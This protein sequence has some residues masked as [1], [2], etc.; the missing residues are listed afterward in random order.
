V[1]DVCSCLNFT[2]EKKDKQSVRCFIRVKMSS[3]EVFDVI[4]VGCG[5][6]GIACAIEL[7]RLNPSVNYLI[8]EGRDRVGGRA[9]TD[10][11]T[12]GEEIPV[13]VEAHYLCHHGNEK[14]SLLQSYHPSRRDRIE[15][16]FPRERCQMSI[17]DGQDGRKIN[18]DQLIEE[19]QHLFDKI[20][21]KVKDF[22]E[23][24]DQSISEWIEK[25]L[26]EIKDDDARLRELVRLHWAFVEVHE[27]SDLCQLSSRS[28]QQGER[29]LE[30]LDL[31]LD[32]GFGSLIEQLARENDLTIEFNRHV[33]HLNID[34][35]QRVQLKTKDE[36]EYLCRY[37]VHTIPLGCLKR[38]SLMFDPPLPSW[39]LNAIDQ[40]GFSLLNKVYLQFSSL[41]SAF[42]EK[43]L[44][45]I[46]VL[47]SR[48][49]FYSCYPQDS[50]LVL[51]V[52][53]DQARQLS[54][55]IR[56]LVTRWASDPF[57]LGSYSSFHRGNDR[58]LV[59]DLSRET[60]Q[61][62]VHWAGEHTNHQGTI[63][64]VDSALQSRQRE[65]KNISL[66]V[67]KDQ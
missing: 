67:S 5:A 28:F 17:F 25:A 33:T 3:R 34:D 55:P 45:R 27:G 24:E 36:R 44:Q 11:Q 8:L 59:E 63:G 14:N 26:E 6:A 53:G 2:F 52:F 50:M 13:D 38:Y 58:R 23:K 19:S 40:M 12:F 57:S 60:H 31:S 10:R 56:W 61:G 49:Q 42:G 22:D 20:E 41:S 54:F 62:R 64:Y 51:F 46:Y 35:N 4:I 48:F 29:N 30:E 66:V 39:K 47:R 1:L 15:V 21:K 32:Q 18:D 9:W 43:D 37:V 65:A 16:D 7:K